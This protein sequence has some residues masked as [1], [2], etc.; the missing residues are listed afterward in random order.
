MILAVKEVASQRT[1]SEQNC[2][3]DMKVIKDTEE[4]DLTENF[5]MKKSDEVTKLSVLNIIHGPVIEDRKSAFQGH[6]CTVNSKED[7]R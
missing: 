7:V 1:N 3:E 6:V 5:I 2:Q 4:N